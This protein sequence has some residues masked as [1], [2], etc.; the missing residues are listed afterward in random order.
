MEIKLKLNLELKRKKVSLE[1]VWCNLIPGGHAVI[2]KYYHFT[3]NKVQEENE[4]IE[5]QDF[6]NWTCV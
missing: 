2:T 5:W 1:N 3:F 6:Q 4:K